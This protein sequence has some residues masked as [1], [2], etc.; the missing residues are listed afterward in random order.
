MTS[1]AMALTMLACSKESTTTGILS[2]GIMADNVVAVGAS[3][4][5]TPTKAL[6]EQE[7][8]N[9]TVD[10][11][12]TEIVQKLYGEI[13]DGQYEVNAGTYTATAYSCT[14]ETADGSTEG[15]DKYGCIRYAGEEE[16]TVSSGEAA[17]VVI[18]C[19]AVNS[20][21][22]VQLEENFLKALVK[23]ETTVTITTNPERDRRPL[24]FGDFTLIQDGKSAIAAQ[25]AFYPAGTTLYIN[26]RSRRIG[27]PS[28]EMLEF[29]IDHTITTGAACW[30]K[31]AIDADLGNAPTGIAIQVGEII[32]V[33][34]NGFSIDGYNSGNLTEDR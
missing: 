6:T 1:I 14:E 8:D 7:L 13:K 24:Q 17:N 12:G 29:A 15:A 31:I 27:R 20:K 5:N 16:F 2:F 19:S 22:T 33:V 32:D 10:V 9:F 26:V 11:P 25:Q 3:A 23:E 34:D 28:G 30:H 21:V 18:A 4:P